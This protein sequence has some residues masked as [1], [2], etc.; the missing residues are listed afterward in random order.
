MPDIRQ[1][2]DGVQLVASEFPIKKAELFGSYAEGRARPDSD[3]D[4]LVE[5]NSSCV[6]LLTL[7]SVK[8]RLEEILDTEVDLIHAPIPENS[9]LEIGRRVHVYG[10]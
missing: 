7:N 3:V 2:V 5:F 8:Y 10:A 9:L 6:S 4:L 1:I